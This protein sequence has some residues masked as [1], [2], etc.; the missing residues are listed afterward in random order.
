MDNGPKSNLVGVRELQGIELER[1][2]VIELWVV[3]TKAVPTAEPCNCGI[4]ASVDMSVL[5]L[6][7][8]GHSPLR[9]TPTVPTI[10]LRAGLG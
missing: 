2:R 7:S 6:G 9:Q 4:G 8:V 3:R 1:S 10:K 5:S